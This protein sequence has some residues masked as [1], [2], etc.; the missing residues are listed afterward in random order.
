MEF[1]DP[2]QAMNPDY[3]WSALLDIPLET[4]NTLHAAVDNQYLEFG[5]TAIS[6]STV[7]G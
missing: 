6:N 4:W 7:G 3:D 1:L 2:S 5:D